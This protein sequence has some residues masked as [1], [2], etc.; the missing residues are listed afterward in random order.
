MKRNT[1]FHKRILD[2][3]K[4]GEEVHSGAMGRWGKVT[5]GV[6]D[7]SNY[8][9]AIRIKPV[10]GGVECITTFEIGDQVDLV[11]EDGEWWIVNKRGA[12]R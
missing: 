10:S 12:K 7:N 3:I 9:V 6:I 2:L 11:R 5:G 4:Q 8:P 1:G